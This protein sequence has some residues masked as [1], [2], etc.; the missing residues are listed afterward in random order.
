M[1]ELNDNTGDKEDK[2]YMKVA[3]LQLKNAIKGL[4]CFLSLFCKA[5]TCS[6]G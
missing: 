6:I 4:V 5:S 3:M 1:V 2:G